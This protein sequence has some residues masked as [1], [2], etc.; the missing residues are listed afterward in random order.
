VIDF[1]FTVTTVHLS[2]RLS[3]HSGFGKQDS[4]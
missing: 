1:I 3:Q 2:S 4:L